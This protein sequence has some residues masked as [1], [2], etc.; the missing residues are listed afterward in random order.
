MRLSTA[1]GFTDALWTS[2][3]C[4][5][6][7]H[8]DAGAKLREIRSRIVQSGEPLLSLD[9]LDKEVAERRGDFSEE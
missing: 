5:S 1:G 7:F 2:S 3:E 6:E 9:E 4:A 8:A